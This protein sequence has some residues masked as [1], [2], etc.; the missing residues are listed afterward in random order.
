M[1][2]LG[3]VVSV[4]FGFLASLVFTFTVVDLASTTALVELL[5][6]QRIVSGY[7]PWFVDWLAAFVDESKGTTMYLG[8]PQSEFLD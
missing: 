6:E 3:H 5:E 2:G 8:F 1:D 4:T 7:V